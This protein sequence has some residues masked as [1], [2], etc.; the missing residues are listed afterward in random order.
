MLTTGEWTEVRRRRN[1]NT[2]LTNY[3][4]T[5]F[6]DDIR[7]EELREPF[8]MFG[9]V[10]DV[11]FGLKKDYQRRN[12]TFVR[13]AGIKDAKV[14][15]LKLQGIKCRGTI[16]EINISKHQRKPKQYQRQE[17]FRQPI[18]RKNIQTNNNHHAQ[19]YFSNVS[20]NKTYAQMEEPEEGEIRPEDVTATDVQPNDHQIPATI[21]LSPTKSLTVKGNEKSP[22]NLPLKPNH[23]AACINALTNI[24]SGTSYEIPNIFSKLTNTH[25]KEHTPIN[26]PSD[27]YTLGP[28]EKL[29]PLGCFGP[30]P[31]N[32]VPFSFTSV[33]K[34]D[35]HSN[36]NSGGGPKHKKRKRDKVALIPPNSNPLSQDLN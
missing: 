6:P 19:Q 36:S 14:M 29:V 2:E 8:S 24:N 16:L 20:G 13:Y 4:V 30:F 9:K 34:N 22:N 31:N 28:L 5:G 25:N 17:T 15:E 33:Q 3:Y 10:A 18:P 11:Y 27:T 26:G 32:N 21:I 35:S 23:E 7:K 12:F 1:W